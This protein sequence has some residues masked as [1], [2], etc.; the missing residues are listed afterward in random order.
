M[1]SLLALFY[2][3]LFAALLFFGPLQA[4]LQKKKSE[5]DARQKPEQDPD[6]SPV[7]ADPEK[8]GLRLSIALVALATGFFLWKIL[9]TP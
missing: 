4:Y 9:T 2:L 1:E 8:M 5:R 3:A 6:K 7:P